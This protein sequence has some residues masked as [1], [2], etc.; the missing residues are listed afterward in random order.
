MIRILHIAS[1]YPPLQVF[2]LGR[3]VNDLAVAQ[4]RQGCD[5]HVVTN[6]IGGRDEEKVVD[7]VHVHRITFPPPPK[8]PD[9]T[10]AV[11][12][13]N[14]SAL[15]TAAQVGE[16]DVVHVH[17]WLTVLAGRMLT[18]LH[19][20]A[21]LVCTIHDTSHGKHFGQLTMPQQY[22]AHLER[23]IGQEADTIICCSQYVR[24]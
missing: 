14:I 18:W 16:P 21:K 20:G 11:Q 2:G 6:S 12:Q 9:D 23:W 3:A 13:F 10:M 17:D 7:G 5:V 15:E 19:P 1:E 22:A 4:A 24:Q 8:P